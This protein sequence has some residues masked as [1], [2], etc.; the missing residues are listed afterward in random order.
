M[1]IDNQLFCTRVRI[2]HTSLPFLKKTPNVY[3][4]NKCFYATHAKVL[5]CLILV[6]FCLLVVNIYLRSL[7]INISSSIMIAKSFNSCIGLRNYIITICNSITSILKTQ[8]LL[9]SGDIETNPGPKILSAIKFCHWNLN[10]LPAQ[11]F[12]KVALIEAFIPTHNFDII[13]LSETFLDSTIPN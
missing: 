12:V 7:K 6:I 10:R 11:D 3:Q 9:I 5:S 13:C 4:N 1:P 2:Y 8:V